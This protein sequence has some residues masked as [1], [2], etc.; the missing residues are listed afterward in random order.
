MEVWDGCN[1]PSSCM[2]AE[3]R[4]VEVG[5][6]VGC[7]VD[8]EVVIACM[9]ECADGGIEDVMGIVPVLQ[10]SAQVPHIVPMVRVEL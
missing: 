3:G 9:A 5:Y 6:M 4:E 7:E 1:W 10:A 2:D 8:R